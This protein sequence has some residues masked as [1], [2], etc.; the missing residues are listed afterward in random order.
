L[1]FGGLVS[2]LRE[3]DDQLGAI[4]Q[5]GVVEGAMVGD[6]GGAIGAAAVFSGVACS[7]RPLLSYLRWRIPWCGSLSR[8]DRGRS[9]EPFRFRTHPR[10]FGWIPFRVF[11]RGTLAIDFLR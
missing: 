11:L 1:G 6:N 4:H 3:I 8:Y 2:A 10:P 9:L 5:G 7:V